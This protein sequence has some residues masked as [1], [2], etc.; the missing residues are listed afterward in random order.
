LWPFK[1]DVTRFDFEVPEEDEYICEAMM[2]TV[3]S[4]IA[5]MPTTG[6]QAS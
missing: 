3:L 2:K 5:S 1:D 4:G 6:T